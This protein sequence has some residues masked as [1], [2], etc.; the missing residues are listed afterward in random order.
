MNLSLRNMRKLRP[1]LEDWLV[2][3]ET[4]AANGESI[5]ELPRALSANLLNQRGSVTSGPNS[6]TAA[7]SSTPINDL[8]SGTS[9]QSLRKRRSR[10]NY[11]ATQRDT[12]EAFFNHT[13]YPNKETLAQLAVAVKLNP[14]IVKTWF[15]NRRQKVRRERE[16]TYYEP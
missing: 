6:S 14:Y 9:G 2:Y 7:N 3:A 16:F 10:T 11:D 5:K 15:C 1:L 4:V 8:C 13:P 12:L